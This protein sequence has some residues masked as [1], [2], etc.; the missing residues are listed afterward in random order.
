M[1]APKTLGGTKIPL[2]GALC[3]P[4]PLDPPMFKDQWFIV[5]TTKKYVGASH[6]GLTQK[7]ASVFLDNNGAV[8]VR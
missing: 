3:P 5:G 1:L 8:L 2:E 6:K 7:L 4:P